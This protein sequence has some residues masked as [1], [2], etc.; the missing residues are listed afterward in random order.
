MTT[1]ERRRHARTGWFDL[2]VNGGSALTL[3]FTKS[4][5][6][7]S[8]RSVTPQVNDYLIVDDVAMV[9]KTAIV[10]T[11]DLDA[12]GVAESRFATDV[13]GDRNLRLL[14]RPQTLAKVARE[15][16]PGD[17]VEFDEVNV[18]I[19]EYTIGGDGPVAMPGQ[20][21]PSSAYTFCVSLSADTADFYADSLQVPEVRTLFTNDVALYTENFLHFPVGAAVPLGFYDANEGLWKG[22]SN[23]VVLRILAIAGDSAQVDVN[24]DSIPDTQGL[25]DTLGISIDSWERQELAKHYSAGDTLWRLA[26]NH[27]SNP[28]G[29]PIPGPQSAPLDLSQGTPINPDALEE[30]HTQVCGSI[31]ECENRVLGQSIPVVGTPYALNYRS[32]RALGD[33]AVRSLRIPVMGSTVP[34]KS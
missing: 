18:R 25:L 32:F 33:K 26:S 10:T 30:L 19:T 29:N 6:L 16:V 34:S 17:T 23:G 4:G 12:G 11:V 31:I 13:D 15:T 8:Q 2:V 5:F 9:G 1:L 22:D 3:R 21:P 28:D 24:N 7:E 14:F 20:L 27:F